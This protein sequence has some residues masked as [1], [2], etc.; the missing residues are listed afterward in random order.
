MKQIFTFIAVMV[1]M[2]SFAAFPGPKTSKISISNNNRK[3]TR[4]KI[5]GAVYNLNNTFVLD[6]IR[7]GYHNISI[8]QVDKMGFRRMEKT[9]YNSN[10]SVMPGQMIN[11]DINRLGQVAV[12]TTNDN[13][14]DRNDHNGRND[15]FDN[16]KGY[17]DHNNRDN[18]YGRH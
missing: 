14:F 17:N 2:S 6:N 11:I 1:S 18:N 4:V 5:D 13:M 3:E 7:A 16:N 12:R 10:M 15:H 8:M 9:I